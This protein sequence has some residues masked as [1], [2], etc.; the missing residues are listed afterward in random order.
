MYRIGFPSVYHKKICI[1][2]FFPYIL[3]HNK[4]TS[5]NNNIRAHDTD[6]ATLDSNR[7][8]NENEFGYL[9]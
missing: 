6:A 5:V 4:K 7:S 3:F 9:R 1:E 8:K 2:S